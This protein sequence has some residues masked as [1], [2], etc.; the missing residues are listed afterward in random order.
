MG[1]LQVQRGVVAVYSDPGR[2]FAHRHERATREVIARQL[3]AVKGLE[4]AGEYQPGGAAAPGPTSG[5]VIAL[6]AAK[7]WG[8]T[9]P[10]R[11]PSPRTPSAAA[12]PSPTRVSLGTK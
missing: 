10:N 6:V 1:D 7:A 5:W 2:G 12:A 3:A 9:P 8:T 4:F 11:S